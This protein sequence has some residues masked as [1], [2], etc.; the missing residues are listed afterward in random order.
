MEAVHNN[1]MGSLLESPVTSDGESCAIRLG[2]I[3]IIDTVYMCAY[4]MCA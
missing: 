1:P 2:A 3:K 4:S